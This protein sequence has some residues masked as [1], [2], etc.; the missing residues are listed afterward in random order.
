MDELDQ[1]NSFEFEQEANATEQKPAPVKREPDELDELIDETLASQDDDFEDDDLSD[2]ENHSASESEE[3]SQETQGQLSHSEKEKLS[4][5]AKWRRNLARKREQAE[6]E[7]KEAQQQALKEREAR[8]AAEKHAAALEKQVETF[9]K[10]AGIDQTVD[11]YQIPAT[12][13]NGSANPA[14][15][16]PEEV[17]RLVESKLKTFLE[18]QQGAQRV[19]TEINEIKNA[20]DKEFARVH[21]NVPHVAKWFDSFTNDVRVNEQKR[22]LLMAISAFPKAPEALHA[23]SKLNGFDRL[24]LGRKIARVHEASQRI[25]SLESNRSNK[26]TYSDEEPNLLDLPTSGSRETKKRPVVERV[27]TQEGF[28]E[29]FEEFW[30]QR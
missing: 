4:K 18:T 30:K 12:G 15:Y 14:S 11:Q 7:A 19:E 5:G 27:K 3:D 8:Y 9:L 6:A 24:P 25:L 10:M 1:E 2:N 16:T 20:L 21:K 23:A 13:A 28:Q 22:E 29:A 17:E 26:R